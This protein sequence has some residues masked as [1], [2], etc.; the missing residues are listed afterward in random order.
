M[1]YIFDFRNILIH[2]FFFLL[3]LPLLDTLNWLIYN[4]VLVLLLLLLILLLIDKTILAIIILAVLRRQVLILD[5][6]TLRQ[7][8]TIRRSLLNKI[9]LHLVISS[10]L[11][12]WAWNVAVVVAALR[13]VYILRNLFYW[14]G[15]T[16]A[17]ILFIVF[18]TCYSSF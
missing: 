15:T 13:L 2:Y 7:V 16:T 12:D 18:D 6:L 14:I 3:E 11:I 4:I 10:E 17:R 1:I 5:F 8:L 9:A